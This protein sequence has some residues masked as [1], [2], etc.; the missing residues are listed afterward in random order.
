[1][2]PLHEQSTRCDSVSEFKIR[3]Q[4]NECLLATKGTVCLFYGQH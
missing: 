2:E 1:M 4:H 3:K